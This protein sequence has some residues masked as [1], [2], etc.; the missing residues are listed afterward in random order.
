MPTVKSESKKLDEAN[1][2]GYH[3]IKIQ[4]LL[5]QLNQS[6]E[7]NIQLS[8]ENLSLRQKKKFLKDKLEITTRKLQEVIVLAPFRTNLISDTQS[9]SPSP[10]RIPFRTTE[11][12][13]SP[14][15]SRMGRASGLSGHISNVTY[16][17]QV[18]QGQH[19]QNLE[20]SKKAIEAISNTFFAQFLNAEMAENFLD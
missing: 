10:R 19:R 2:C 12:G 11:L 3:R 6:V 17:D 9:P 4:Q 18:S 14:S 16:D 13:G 20:E 15:P 7:Q 8:E 5:G 1:N